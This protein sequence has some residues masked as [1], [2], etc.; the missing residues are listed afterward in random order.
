M[1]RETKKRNSRRH[2]HRQ[3]EGL[4]P[5][6]PAPSSL[7]QGQGPDFATQDEH[8]R[9]NNPAAEQPLAETNDPVLPPIAP[10]VRSHTPENDTADSDK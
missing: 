4:P 5:E 6:V 2:S 1:K 7:H 10:Q 3:A 8:M 9:I